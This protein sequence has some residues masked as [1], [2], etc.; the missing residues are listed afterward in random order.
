[1][2]TILLGAVIV[3]LGPIVAELYAKDDRRALQEVVNRTMRLVFVASLPLAA[4]LI[5]AGGSYLALFGSEFIQASTALAI[6]AI[7]QLVNVGA[8]PVQMLLVMTGQPRQAAK[9][10][11]ASAVVNVGLNLALIPS[12]GVEGAAFATAISI[13]FW[14]VAL[15]HE[16]RKRLGISIGLFT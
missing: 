4:V 13:V 15:V 11:A 14:N 2:L 1:L 9:W 3:P 8:G 10:L 5:L 16:I 7:A 12:F 6:L